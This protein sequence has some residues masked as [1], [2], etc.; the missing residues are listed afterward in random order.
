MLRDQNLTRDSSCN[1]QQSD[2]TTISTYGTISHNLNFGLNRNF[3]GK[4][5]VA[6]VSQPIIGVRFLK[7]YKLFVNHTNNSLNNFNRLLFN[8][9]LRTK[10]NILK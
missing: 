9:M 7:H 3:I 1:L 6:D 10:V 5:R 2:K 8:E 4:F